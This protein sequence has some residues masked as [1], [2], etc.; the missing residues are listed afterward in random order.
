[1][2]LFLTR[3]FVIC[4]FIFGSR[5]LHAFTE[6]EPI[7]E[8]T[9]APA[10]PSETY[11]LSSGIVPE[12]TIRAVRAKTPITIDG[13]GDD[14]IW[15]KAPISDAF[16]ERTPV[17][18][19]TPSDLTTFQVAYDSRA[20]YILV[21]SEKPP[22]SSLRSSTLRRDST[23]IFSD[24]TITVKIDPQHDHQTA[25]S[26]S[27]NPDGAQIDALVLNNGRNFILAWDG[28]WE[29][30]IHEEETAYF[31][32]M[33]IPFSIMGV[34]GHQISDM[35]LNVNRSRNGIENFD[36]R[37]II[38]PLSPM[39]ASAFGDIIGLKNIRSDNAIDFVPF[40]L[41]RT[42]FAPELTV[43]PSD[44][45]NLTAG[46]DVRVRIGAYNHFELS[47]LTDFAQV[48]VDEV[49]VANNRFPLFFP[50]RRPFFLR[51][52][53]VFQFGVPARNQ[54]FFSRRIGLDSGKPVPILS[55]MKWY[56]Q[57]DTVSYGFINVQTMAHTASDSDGHPIEVAPQNFS[58]MRAKAQ[59]GQWLVGGLFGEKINLFD[60]ARN[61]ST[62]GVDLE[63]VGDSGRLR[64]YNFIAATNEND[65]SRLVNPDSASEETQPFDWSEENRLTD[66]ERLHGDLREAYPLLPGMSAHTSVDYRSLHFRPNLSWTWSDATFSPEQGYFRR[67]NVAEHQARAYGAVRP[68]FWGIQELEGG[69]RVS[70]TTDPYYSEL[71]EQ[72]ATVYGRLLTTW[73]GLAKYEY[74]R[75]QD[76][77]RNDFTLYGI[78]VDAGE[79]VGNT[80]YVFAGLPTAWALFGGMSYEYSD[81]FNGQIHKPGMTLSFRPAKYFFLNLQ[82]QHPFGFLGELEDNF[83]FGYANCR[84]EV[85]IT[86]ALLFDTAFRFSM[87]PNSETVGLQSRLRWQYRPG[88]DLF[89]VYRY[90]QP[91]G[92]ESNAAQFDEPFHELTVKVT[93]YSSSLTPKFN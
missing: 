81:L 23:S 82:Y 61:H 92:I 1:M 46:T 45:P 16:I 52:L 2:I 70:I 34:G 15:Q 57:T 74:S 47:L 56:G 69:P 40:G 79:Y 49:Q 93:F 25:Y 9:D 72:R 90:D 88:S 41:V 87:A 35:G 65:L 5:G 8:T 77:V 32:E 71:L 48:E 14:P 38:P 66:L 80:H 76:T 18:G 59:F 17:L 63:Y 62:A 78:G 3:A 31:V 36:W 4:C 27:V 6:Q 30:E 67:T 24:D 83:N 84:T 85:S 86:R 68:N 55:G 75:V 21:R 58:I 89:V 22:N 20:L 91:F 12:R 19:Q 37:L 73:G 10:Q 11:E 64:W 50:E 33:R 43:D 54:L 42:N 51:G 60:D 29:A 39:T 7:A 53:E 26:F 44:Q 28:I 13:K